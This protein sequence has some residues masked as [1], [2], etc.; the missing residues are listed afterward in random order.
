VLG[1]RLGETLTRR[2]DQFAASRRVP[3]SLVTREAIQE[4]LDRHDFD[5]AEF[6]RQVRL[7]AASEGDDPI[8]DQGFAEFD[9]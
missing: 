1:V 9:D 2:L 4:Y 8:L 3:K 7:V 5:E 6:V